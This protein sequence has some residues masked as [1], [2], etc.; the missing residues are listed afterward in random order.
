M[1]K[2]IIILLCLSFS[3]SSFAEK[4]KEKQDSISNTERIIDKYSGKVVEGFNNVVEK[5]VP[6]AKQGFET[7]VRLQIA[8]GI[9]NLLPLIFFLFFLYSSNKEYDRI[10]TILSS[11]N[12]PKHMDQKNGPF[13]EDNITPRLIIY[14]IIALILGILSLFTTYTGITHVVAPEWYAIKEIIKLFK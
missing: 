10:N 3:F 9:A 6:I 4:T 8:K 5:A 1:K 7:A 11:D 13:D 14:F 12:I 2:L